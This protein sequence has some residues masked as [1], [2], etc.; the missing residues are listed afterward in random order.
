MTVVKDSRHS[1]VVG[2]GGWAVSNDPSDT[3]V[4]Y[5]LGSCLAI[6]IYDPVV[7]VGGLVHVMLPQP[8]GERDPN[9]LGRYVD[10]GVPLL[11]KKAYELGAIKTRMEVRVAGGAHV[12]KGRADNFQIG[13]RNFMALK[14]LLWKNG[15]L[16][17]AHDV[18]GDRSRTVVIEVG[19]GTVTVNSDQGS[20]ILG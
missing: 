8:K 16:L 18:G 11:F 1:V 9:Q 20:E 4:T 10:S 17:K 2:I 15:V 6:C 19:T 12:L 3:I 5:G 7:Q 13:K 14:K